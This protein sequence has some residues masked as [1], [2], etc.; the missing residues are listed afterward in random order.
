[1]SVYIYSDTSHTFDHFHQCIHAKAAVKHN[2]QRKNLRLQFVEHLPFE[3][4]VLHK[5]CY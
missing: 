2:T 5:L 3:L 1:M 4:L